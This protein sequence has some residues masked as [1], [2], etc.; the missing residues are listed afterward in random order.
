MI[1]KSPLAFFRPNT[2]NTMAPAPNALKGFAG[3]KSKATSSLVSSFPP[4]FS[5]SQIRFHEVIEH[6]QSAFVHY[7]KS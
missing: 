7:S 5:P 1:L 4:G 2:V 6:N 3:N